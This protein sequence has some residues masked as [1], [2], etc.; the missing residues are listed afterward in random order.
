M[1]KNGITRTMLFLLL[2]RRSLEWSL[3][4]VPLVPTGTAEV[5]GQHRTGRRGEF[6][7]LTWKR[8]LRP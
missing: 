6:K 3:F 1:V 2:V 7:R 5:I 4:G 8:S